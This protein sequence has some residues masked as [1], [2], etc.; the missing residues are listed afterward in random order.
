MRSTL[1]AAALCAGFALCA[2][3]AAAAPKVVIRT[4]SGDITV[5]G[6]ASAREVKSNGRIE[7]AGA[8]V[9][10]RGAG[11]HEALTVTVPAGAEVGA[12]SASG[13]IKIR[14]VHGSVSGKTAN[15]DITVAQAGRGRVT[16]KSVSGAVRVSGVKG[17]LRVKT[18]SGDVLA[19]GQLKDVDIT[20]VSGTIRIDRLSGGGGAVRTTSGKVTVKG[21]LASRSKVRIRSH[22]GPV[23]VD[24]SVP[25]GARYELRSFSG[26]LRVARGR[27]AP[28]D[29]GK[30]AE[31]AVGKG[32]AR[33]KLSSFS[34]DIMLRLRP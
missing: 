14:G 27:G 20:S 19:T 8:E 24:L 1:R 12:R 25:R 23:E 16:V 7:R 15:G 11:P 17:G 4:A 32:L 29:A 33:I 31:G 18:V 3:E 2:S 6:S 9:R 34:G 13:Q 21:A 26:R 22:S 30:R 28:L 10:V 5:V